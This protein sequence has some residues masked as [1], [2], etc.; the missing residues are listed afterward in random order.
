MA[1]PPPFGSPLVMKFT[2]YDDIWSAS[3]RSTSVQ[4]WVACPF[5]LFHANEMSAVCVAPCG[6]GWPFTFWMCVKK[7]V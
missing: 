2:Q 5:G 7:Y 4:V 3:F 1:G 6:D